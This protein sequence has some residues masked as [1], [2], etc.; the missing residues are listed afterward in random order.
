MTS[1]KDF[2]LP[3]QVVVFYYPDYNYEQLRQAIKKGMELLQPGTPLFKSQETILVKPNLLAADTPDKCVTTHPLV[4]QAVAEYLLNLGITVT[5]GDSPGFNSMER[6]AAV[7][8]IDQV[9][10]Q[11]TLHQADFKNGRELSYTMG[12]QNKK[13]F[14]ANGVLAA[15]GLVSVAKFKTHGLTGITASIKNQFGCIPGLL[16]GEFHVKLPDAERFSRMLVDLNLCLQPRLY[17]L[18]GIMA[19]EGNGPRGGQPCRLGL[20]AMSTDPV[21]L[22]ATACRICR[23]NPYQ[24]PTI[25]L[26]EEMG[27][28]TARREEIEILG[29]FLEKWQDVRFKPASGSRTLSTSAGMLRNHLVAKPVIEKQ[30][31]LQCGV[32][33]QMCPLSPSAVDW[34][35][36]DKK[37]ILRY[38][39]SRCIR[40]YC[41][42]EVCPE[43]AIHLKTPWLGKIAG[44]HRGK[45]AKS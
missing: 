23:I 2:R 44:I 6:V 40:C 24:I 9:A 35:D 16:K 30:K 21:A 5:Y 13:F 8:G 11:L 28:G 45:K 36:P 7:S 18:D 34:S 38:D 33:I 32:C 12:Q 29:D 25:R 22:D 1:T 3:S 20:L 17:V 26:G 27:L 39:F 37:Q 41:C 43:G 14:I 10:K 4:F 15:D 31:C 42:Q 19:M